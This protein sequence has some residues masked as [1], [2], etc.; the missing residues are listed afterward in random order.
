MTVPAVKG[1]EELG[2]FAQDKITCLNW[3][4]FPYMPSVDFFVGHSAEKLF[5]RFEV[6]EANAKAVS[7]EANGP[8][9]EDSCVEFFVKAPDDDHYFNFETNCIGTG[10]AARRLSRENSKF[11]SPEQ[12][13]QVVR[14]S[15]LPHEVTDIKDCKWSLE[16]EIPFSV[17]G[18]TS[19]PKAL[20]ANFYKCGDKTAITHFVSWSPIETIK[21]DFHRPEFFGHLILA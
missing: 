20:E 7:L 19:Y 13:A 11:L 16:L 1:F 6:E 2:A 15:S 9:W 3:K 12:M 21:P 8:V 17:L 18:C 14:R 10:L 5:I 4:D